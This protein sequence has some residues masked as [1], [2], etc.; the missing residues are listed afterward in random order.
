MKKAHTVADHKQRM[1][2]ARATDT[3]KSIDRVGL[4]IGIDDLTAKQAA[5]LQ[6]RD[7]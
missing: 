4:H 5:D 2:K 3:L 7:R 1:D 6:R